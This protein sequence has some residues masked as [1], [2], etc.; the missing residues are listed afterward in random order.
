[1][2]IVPLIQLK[3]RRQELHLNQNEVAALL[4]LADASV[5]SRHEAGL[6]APDLHA[7][8]AYQVI[9]GRTLD[10]LFP[11][12]FEDVSADIA[13]RASELANTLRNANRDA[14][15]NAVLRKLAE[16]TGDETIAYGE[17]TLW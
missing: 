8:I 5:V 15:V 11:E 6:H 1:M 4:G 16:L 3:R 9:Y 10:K 14:R 13:A 12:A 2:Q 17:N 7:A